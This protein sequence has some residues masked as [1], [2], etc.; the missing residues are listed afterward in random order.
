M[1]GREGQV[2]S[3]FELWFPGLS[4][5]TWYPAGELRSR[6]LEQLRCGEPRWQERDRIPSDRYFIFRGGDG[7]RAPG[8]QTRS[9]DTGGHRPP[10]GSAPAI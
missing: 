1:T 10:G 6:V 5:G 8:Q 3:E 7:S 9:T 4:P 2:R